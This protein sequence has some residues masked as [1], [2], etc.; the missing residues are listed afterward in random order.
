MT[1]LQKTKLPNKILHKARDLKLEIRARFTSCPTSIHNNVTS[2]SQFA[3]PEWAEKILRDRLPEASDPN[4]RASGA[5]TPEEY[6]K[7]V[8]TVCGMACT[9]MALSFFGK[10][11]LPPIT[12]A[13]DALEAGVYQEHSEQLSGMRYRE[14]VDWIRDYGL[15]AVVYSHL[16]VAGIR[17]I[18][19]RGGLVIT[20]VNPNIRGYKTGSDDQKGGHLVLVTGYDTR[21]MTLTLNNPSGF[22]CDDTHHEHV[23]AISEFKRYFA[24][25][26]IALFDA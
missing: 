3:S 7:W 18:L 20:S 23:L 8:T 4:W 19:S 22:V 5:T 17:Y 6:E 13:K 26:G 15:V 10:R 24:G 1:S 2:V 11:A 12:L 16:S 14:Y 21:G 9:T 25:R